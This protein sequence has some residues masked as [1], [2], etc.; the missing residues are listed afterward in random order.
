LDGFLPGQFSNRPPA[1][2]FFPAIVM[3]AERLTRQQ[4]ERMIDQHAEKCS[5]K[6]RFSR[7]LPSAKSL[8]QLLD[9]GNSEK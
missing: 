4:I 3:R 5:Q 6:D 2:S 9:I 1:T 7:P 8:K